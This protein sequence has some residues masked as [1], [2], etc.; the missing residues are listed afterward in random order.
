MNR[1][2]TFFIYISS[3][4]FCFLFL[5][6][7]NNQVDALENS[8][9]TFSC[10]D[11]NGGACSD[12]TTDGYY[13]LDSINV[14]SE[15]VTTLT[16][17][18]VYDDGTHGEYDVESISSNVIVSDASLTLESI[19]LPTNLVTI[20]DNAF[21]NIASIK[22]F[23]IPSSVKTVGANIFS[24][25]TN[26]SFI[27]LNR[28]IFAMEEYLRID[29]AAFT[30]A[31]VEKIVCA[32]HDIYNYFLS[33][34]ESTLKDAPLVTVVNY[35]Y[36]KYENE[37]LTD[38]QE[39][40]T[41]YVGKN[42]VMVYIPNDIEVNGLNFLGWYLKVGDSYTQVSLGQNLYFNLY[43][44][45][46]SIYPHYE[47]K[48]LTFNVDSKDAN[49]KSVN[50]V[51]YDGTNNLIELSVSGLSHEAKDSDDFDHTITWN[52]VVSD[53]FILVAKSDNVYLSEVDQSGTYNCVIDYT[54]TYMNKEYSNSV[55]VSKSVK[56]NKAPL[57]IVVNDFSKV[58]GE[59][60]TDENVNYQVNGLLNGDN[61]T[62]TTYDYPHSGN[63]NVGNYLNAIKV[64]INSI[65]G[66]QKE[67]VAN[68]NI[69]YS[70]G[71]YTVTKKV[72]DV[73]YDTDLFF[74]Y[75]SEI[76]I[77]K[78]YIDNNVYGAYTNNILVT[79]T[80]E[81][82]STVGT[83]QINGVSAVSSENYLA[84]YKSDLTTGVVTIN[85]KKVA[86]HVD[87]DNPIYDGNN[88]VL[89]VYYIDANNIR[90]YLD[91]QIKF[92]GVIV[93]DVINAGDYKILIDSL[94]DRNYEFLT[95][96]YKELDLHIDK[97]TSIATYS[98]YQTFI[99]SG[100][101][102][103]PLV[104]I[105]NEEQTPI[106]TC[107]SGNLQGDYCKN[108]GSYNVIVVFNET[109]NYH[110]LQTESIVVSISKYMIN[111]SPK[112]FDVYYGEKVDLK[113]ELII[114]GEKVIA[115]YKTN[116]IMGSPVGTYNITGVVIQD[117]F[118]GADHY[119]YTGSVDITDSKEKVNIVKR[120]VNIIYYNY[121][122]LVYDGKVKS[123]GV[124]A[125][126][127]ISGRVVNNLN[128][129]LT[130]DEGEIKNAGTYHLRT[131]FEDDRYAM[132][133]SNLL[134]FNIA[135]ADYDISNIQ[136][137]D[138]SYVLNFRKHSLNV[139]GILPQGV[140]VSYTIDGEEG[141]SSAK[142]FSHKVVAKFNID[143]LNYN[144]IDDME[145]TLYIDMSWVFIVFTVVIFI[146]G[147]S[148]CAII[149]YIRYRRVHPKKIKLKIKNVIKEDLAA[150]R[151]ATSVKEVLGDEEVEPEH[152]EDEDDLIENVTTSQSFIDRIYAAD[153]ELKYYYSEVKNELLSYKGVTH[154]VDRKYEVFHHGT[155]QIAKL[156]ICN[157]VLRLYV[158]LEPA[159]YDKKQYNHRDMS[160]FECHARTPLR[161]DV[162]T[163]ESLRHAKVFIRILRKKENLK[164]V[165]S[166]VKV[167]Y[168]KFYTLKE[169]VFPKI[170]KKMFTIKK[171]GKK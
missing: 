48:E 24:D 128:L 160:K 125:V 99:Y 105:N 10:V 67:R 45:T 83:Y 29:E 60:L 65:T 133:N 108:A 144:P 76:V 127:G 36:Y 49:G 32:N 94:E 113:E 22:D 82:G 169:N 152:I 26:V 100:E 16:I 168:E 122:D 55:T 141:N 150:K 11:R 1:G 116:A 88:K 54:Y 25:N 14:G 78:V 170:F 166:F 137:S 93:E 107:V 77:N 13:V 84:N 97:A 9:Y 61:I 70:Y 139:E 86:T 20:S 35:N 163:T 148:V 19:T 98:S 73:Y 104:T 68:Y 64:R 12:A 154:S 5:I 118:T 57:Y 28:Y 17:P 59:Y 146:A 132:T 39:T 109:S 156:S 75:G 42:Q 27:Y 41:Y 63:I 121:S 79:F 58:Y 158:N 117:A 102:I 120:P 129:T 87:V 15:V 167:D 96:D 74:D 31:N 171:K 114:N 138:K 153:S 162:N 69:V 52:K 130:C 111:L 18:S 145:A 134:V 4:V 92:N 62:S 51:Q 142:A 124:Y 115:K 101:K 8:A 3:V 165:S 43:T 103:D 161:I 30:N 72:L 2:K 119:N 143:T 37:K 6:F 147:I 80:K 155:R 159:K 135:K 66:N 53:S 85:P 110:R 131:Y 81:L 123:V 7:N 151:V 71:D 164:A 50:N 47:L 106:Y 38:I 46:Y 157:H 44:T 89:D 112:S 56:I 33:D 34:E 40:K 95:D 90:V 136:F 23:N 126:D 149:L 21:T 91:Y 140:S